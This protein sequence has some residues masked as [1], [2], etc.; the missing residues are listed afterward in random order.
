LV[1]SVSLPA[2]AAAQQQPTNTAMAESST[3]T[4]LAAGS[5]APVRQTLASPKVSKTSPSVGQ[6]IPRP[7]GNEIA[8]TSPSVSSEPAATTL[9]PATGS[10][11]TALTAAV[12]TASTDAD[13]AYANVRIKGYDIPLPGPSDTIEG[14][15]WG[16]RK[17]LASIGIGWF[18]YAP[19]NLFFNVLN[20]PRGKPQVF[21]G[22]KFTWGA[23]TPFLMTYDL[24]RLGL[25]DA[26]FTMGFQAFATSWNP[27]GPRQFSL[28]TMTVYKSFFH[29]MFEVKAGYMANGFEFYNPY[30]AGN[31]AAGIFG[32]SASIPAEVGMS[33]TS[34]T[35]PGANVKLNLGHFYDKAGVQ[36]AISPD[37][38]VVE[39]Q[40]NP[41][42]FDFET[43][44]AGAFYIN[45]IGYRTVSGVDQKQT[46]LRAAYMKSTSQY[47]SARN[48]AR[49]TGEYGMYAL[50]DH[51]FVQLQNTKQGAYRG[52]YAGFSAM[53]APPAI[54]KFSQFYEARFYAIG[55]MKSRPRDMISLIFDDNVFSG[56][57]VT[58]ARNAGE[59]A[60][61]SAQTASVSYTAH[62]D[63]GVSLGF[64][65]S[66][67]NHP[68]PITFGP[69]T[70]SALNLISTLVVDY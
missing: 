35:K 33:T 20:T 11:P 13:A 55:L 36:M 34:Y 59:M 49:V 29:K 22:Q 57:Y 63:R 18:A 40:Q 8:M 19:I 14:P 62:V 70:G 50:G 2:M 7:N 3:T 25:G 21:A 51:Q 5:T 54:N 17:A 60:H 52:L 43:P 16:P 69:E 48:N 58:Q 65:V 47:L 9:E 12:P 53:Y 68:T 31:F 67:T 6:K 32:T 66:Y 46:W 39:K 15:D 27:T 10:A 64:G 4:P 37:G 30:I 28:A 24:G 44:H 45:E 56:D 61:N 42:G 38:T 1:A 41:T 23:G 26:Q